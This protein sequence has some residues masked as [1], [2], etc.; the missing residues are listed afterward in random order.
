V[1]LRRPATLTY[2]LVPGGITE[3]QALK[4][5]KMAMAHPTHA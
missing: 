2:T 1:G 5:A 3:L 4:T